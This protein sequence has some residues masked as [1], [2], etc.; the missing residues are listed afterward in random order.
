MWLNRHLTVCFCTLCTLFTW[1][2]INFT[3]L[4]VCA[5]VHF[6]VVVICWVLSKEHADAIDWLDLLLL[7]LLFCLTPRLKNGV[8]VCEHTIRLLESYTFAPTRTCVNVRLVFFCF[9]SFAFFFRLYSNVWN[10]RRVQN[11]SSRCSVVQVAPGSKSL[12]PFNYCAWIIELFLRDNLQIWTYFDLTRSIFLNTN[13]E[14]T[15]RTYEAATATEATFIFRR[16]S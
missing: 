14:C 7:L 16:I 6:V 12:M 8:C 4:A 9:F 10:T 11:T 3:V 2:L 5:C 1:K 13:Y 15:S